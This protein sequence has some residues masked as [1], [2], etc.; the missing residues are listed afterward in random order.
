MQA[1]NNYYCGDDA[2]FDGVLDECVQC[3][4][5]CYGEVKTEF[6]VINCPGIALN[7]DNLV[8]VDFNR[9]T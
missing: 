3:G 6:C 2:Y 8:F 5:I 1:G 4:D 7:Y 9:L